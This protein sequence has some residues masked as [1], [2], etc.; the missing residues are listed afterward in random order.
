[1]VH[2]DLW[3][4]RST[5]ARKGRPPLPTPAAMAGD[6]RRP[7]RAPGSASPKA[8]LVHSHISHLILLC[9]LLCGLASAIVFWAPAI[10]FTSYVNLPITWIIVGIYVA[11]CASAGLDP[12]TSGS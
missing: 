2:E 1:M 11:L 6:A 7:T 4:A 3:L 5:A 10:T 8:E 12:A 9:S